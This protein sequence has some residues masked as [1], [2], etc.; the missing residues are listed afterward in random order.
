M[1]NFNMISEKRSFCKTRSC[2]RLLINIPPIKH[3]NRFRRERMRLILKNNI[4]DHKLIKSTFYSPLGAGNHFLS[5]FVQPEQPWYR[6]KSE[7][8]R[9]KHEPFPKPLVVSRLVYDFLS[10]FR[11]TNTNQHIF[12]YNFITRTFY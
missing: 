11:Y 12:Q 6:L 8:S 10:W 2:K 9:T 4:H 7:Q 5:S 3:D 1:K